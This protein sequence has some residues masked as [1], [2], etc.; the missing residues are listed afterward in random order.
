MI[1]VPRRNLYL[2]ERKW[3]FKKFQRGIVQATC[4]YSGAPLCTAGTSTIPN[5]S[6][7]E[8]FP[9]DA[10]CGAKWDTDGGVYYYHGV[11]Q[12]FPGSRNGG[13]WQGSC[14]PV[15]YEGRW[16]QVS[17]T[18]PT[19]SEPAVNVWRAMDVGDVRVEYSELGSGEKTGSFVFEL[20][21]ASDSVEI[22][23]DP[24]TMFVDV[25]L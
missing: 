23:T 7:I 21:R 15:G 1:I 9:D 2:P 22:L 3:G 25:E 20:R 8:N 4:V 17:G 11:D 16:I 13:T 12:A 5:L 18:S 24:F 6:D 14:D 19:S 10:F